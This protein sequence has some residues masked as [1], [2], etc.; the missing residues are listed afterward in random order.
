LSGTSKLWLPDSCLPVTA[1][2]EPGGERIAAHER[3]I[4]NTVR[5]GESDGTR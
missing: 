2:G 5:V 4:S 3:L 1:V